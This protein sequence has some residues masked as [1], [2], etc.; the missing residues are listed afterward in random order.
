MGR[1]ADVKIGL[2]QFATELDGIFADFV[3][4]SDE[5]RQR[6]LSAGADIMVDKLK[7]ASPRSKNNFP[8][9]WTKKE[10]RDLHAV[11]NTTMVAGSKDSGKKDIPLVNILE[12]KQGN[13]H[14]GF[15]RRTQQSAEN[16]VINTIKNKLSEE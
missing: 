2:S 10:Y 12:Y 8:N 14:Y 9:G 11:H 5:K 1:N 6:A 15:V 13:R 3:K 4:A 7:A 16:E